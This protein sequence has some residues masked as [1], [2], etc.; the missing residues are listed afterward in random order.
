MI[1]ERSLRY[2]V[3]SCGHD[4]IHLPITNALYVSHTRARTAAEHLV[5]HLLFVGIW[6]RIRAANPCACVEKRMC[7]F[8]DIIDLDEHII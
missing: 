4:F 3:F 5:S 7:T 6:N 1:K 8:P 2:S